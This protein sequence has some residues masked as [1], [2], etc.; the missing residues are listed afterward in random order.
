MKNRYRHTGPSDLNGSF[1]KS[2][3]PSWGPHNKDCWETTKSLHSPKSGATGIC[4]VL[5]PPVTVYIRGPIQ[6]IYIYIYT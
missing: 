5:H 4:W 6:G 2:A 1:P 3:V